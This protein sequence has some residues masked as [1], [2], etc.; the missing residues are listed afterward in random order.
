MTE[1]VKIY[2]P[3]RLDENCALA[4]TSG[5][6]RAESLRDG[7][8]NPQWS[9]SGSGTGVTETIT[10]IFADE[11]GNP[12]SREIDRI[13]LLGTN[14]AAIAAQWRDGQEVWHDVPEC[15]LSGITGSSVIVE[16]AQTFSAYAFRLNI[17][18]ASPAN[19]EKLLG[20]LKLCRSI[21]EL[22]R[23]LTSVS[24]GRTEKGAAYYLSGGGL[25]AWREYSKRTASLRA[26]N[27]S[28]DDRLALA[29]AFSENL[30]L[31][32]SLSDDGADA[33]AVE[34][35]RAA[36]PQETYDRKSGLYTVSVELRER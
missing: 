8:L 6:N 25:V 11:W 14:A 35:A 20:E 36:P 32:F 17:L 12:V 23:A 4:V 30:F 9:S 3:N 16:T 27:L 29:N 26:E 15:S 7:R 21:M 13:L 10:A 33:R 19:S 31:S 22:N 34:F 1:P 5:E 24:L 18:E 28:P 2:S